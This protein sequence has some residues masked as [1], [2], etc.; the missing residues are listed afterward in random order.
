MLGSFLRHYVVVY[1][2]VYIIYIV[3]L[4]ISDLYAGCAALHCAIDAH[5][6]VI[7]DSKIDSRRTIYQL[8][9]HGAKID[10]QVRI[11]HC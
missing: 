5:D 11:V 8:I 4:C 10:V 9:R 3:W 6:K 1:V 7:H 2:V